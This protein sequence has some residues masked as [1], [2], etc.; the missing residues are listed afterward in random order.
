MSYPLLLFC[1]V[2]GFFLMWSVIPSIREM[3][4]WSKNW[5]R[6]KRLGFGA[7]SPVIRSSS[8]APARQEA[9]A[10]VLMG[11]ALGLALTILV[12]YIHQMTR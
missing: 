2:C 6:R 12:Y 11:A 8:W 4:R 10:V 5:L 7:K 9:V 3:L 1:L